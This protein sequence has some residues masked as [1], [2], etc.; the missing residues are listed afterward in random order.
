VVFK[1]YRMV[2]SDRTATALH[3]TYNPALCPSNAP[4]RELHKV[5]LV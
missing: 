4:I 5:T 3:P 2:W 1:F